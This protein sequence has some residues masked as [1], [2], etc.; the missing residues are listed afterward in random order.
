MSICGCPG[1]GG[2]SCSHDSH[3][4]ERAMYE[5]EG[6]RKESQRKYVTDCAPGTSSQLYGQFYCQQS[7]ERGEFDHR[8]Q[9]YG[10]SVLERVTYRVANDSGIVQ[11]S[12]FLLQFDFNNFFGVV[13]GATSVGHKDGLIEPKDRDRDQVPNKIKRLNECKCQGG[14][15]DGQEN[16]KHALLRVLSADFN[17]LLTVGNRSFFDS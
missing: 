12:A 13:P 6:H 3:A 9:G 4:V 14:E 2:R 11:R 10:R 16:I 8:V 1:R 7:E 5:S 17:Y 15:K